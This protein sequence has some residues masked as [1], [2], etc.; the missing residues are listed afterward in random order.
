MN[1][2]FVRHAGSILWKR[3]PVHLT[4]FLTLKCNASCP[5][6]FYLQSP[7]NPK[8]PA[9]ELSLDEI[10]R[11][12]RSLGRLLWL[13]FSG[14]EVYLR[15]DLVEISKVFYDRNRPAVMLFPSNGLLPDLIR[16]QTER[17]AKHCRNSVVVVKLSLDGIGADHDMLRNTRDNFDKT[18]QTYALLQ[19]LL[20]TC[21]NFEL[22]FN[23]VLT[24]QNQHKADG[25]IDFVN[26]LDSRVTHTI[27]MV[28]GNLLDNGYKQVEPDRYRRAT[29]T[30][31]TRLRERTGGRH[32]FSGARLKAAQDVLQRRFIHQTLTGQDR[33][34]PC[35]AGKLNL[36]L[37]ESG[38]VYPCEILAQS[39]GNVRDHDCD[40]MQVIRTGQAADVLQSIADSNPHCRTCTHECNYITNILFNP[41]MYPALMTE[42]LR[43]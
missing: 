43:L 17:I 31:A 1:P 3:R 13:A 42:Y 16:E 33:S 20:D 23:T 2:A 26:G 9:P 28:R 38:E 18:M 15:K 27:S 36:V 22:G 35:Y 19:G 29:E 34:L 21:P 11:I 14:G 6:C 4:F 40:I 41:A 37:T 32:R 12:S 39:L 8:T 25:I 30:L 5:F 7:D 10:E 24:A